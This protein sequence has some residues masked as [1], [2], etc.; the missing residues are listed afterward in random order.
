MRPTSA[1]RPCMRPAAPSGTKQTSFG[2]GGPSQ[3][4]N[5][6]AHPSATN[7]DTPA[8]R[9]SLALRGALHIWLMATARDVHGTNRRMIPGTERS[10]TAPT[11]LQ[12][13]RATTVTTDV[14]TP[15]PTITPARGMEAA[16]GQIAG[17]PALLA[18]ADCWDQCRGV[19]TSTELMAEAM[20]QQLLWAAA[21][22]V[23]VVVLGTPT[24]RPPML[25]ASAAAEVWLGFHTK[26][27][28]TVT[29]CVGGMRSGVFECLRRV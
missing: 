11:T 28:A 20:R 9:E 26:K 23:T 2:R 29:W 25:T 16:A 8:N 6:L 21:A 24:Q 19:A 15:M 3:P 7:P 1:V 17:A 4:R 22:A 5:A 12:R 14:T 13:S 27:R 18:S 10:L